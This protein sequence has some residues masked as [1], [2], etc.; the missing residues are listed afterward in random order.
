[1]ERRGMEAAGKKTD[2][3]AAADI[4]A[5]PMGDST[6]TYR[7]PT[8][9]SSPACT[10]NQAYLHTPIHTHIQHTPTCSD[11]SRIL[12]QIYTHVHPC[13]CTARVAEVGYIAKE[14]RC[15]SAIM[16]KEKKPIT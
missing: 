4:G 8:R 3:Q 7:R 15:K 14:E 1:M 13:M 16:V 9:A 10:C 11:D 12:T 5:A 2:M 6:G